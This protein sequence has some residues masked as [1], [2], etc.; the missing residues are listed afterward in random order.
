MPRIQICTQPK[1]VLRVL[2]DCLQLLIADTKTNEQVDLQFK[3][4]LV[5]GTQR[6]MVTLRLN[7]FL[8]NTWLPVFLAVWNNKDFPIFVRITFW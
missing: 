3:D 6:V 1:L 7:I 8:L 2:K 5:N 4:Q